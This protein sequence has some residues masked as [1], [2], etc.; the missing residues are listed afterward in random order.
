[1]NLQQFRYVKTIAAA[2]SFSEAAKQLYVTQPSLS[3]AVKE[4]EEEL[5]TELFLRSK[6]GVQ[7]TEAGRDFLVYAQQILAQTEQLKQH[8]AG[9]Q[10]HDF[11]IL[12]QHYDLLSAP[13]LTV[14]NQFRQS[15]Q[16]FH[17]I[18]TTTQQILA[19]LRDFTGDL[20]ILYLDE[21]NRKILERHFTQEGFSYEVLGVFATQIFLRKDHPLA[22]Q[23][24]ILREELAAYPQVRFK[25]EA[26]GGESFEE[27]PLAVTAGGLDLA[28]E[29]ARIGTNERDREISSVKSQQTSGIPHDTNLPE[30]AC[31]VPLQPTLYTN[32]RGTLM[33][34]LVQSDAYASG[35]GI[36]GGFVAEHICLRPLADGTTHQLVAVFNDRRKRSEMAEAFIAA[37]G[38]ALSYE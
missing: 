8:F 33:N 38:E 25:Q 32:D 18:E 27:D 30:A 2:G 13:F 35:L 1:M 24:V 3:Q 20:G 12:S 14:V 17:L 23:K 6:V 7:L 36:I 4:L 15:C 11:T 22:R 26:Y 5:A 31:E 19:G 16:E 37:V 29:M 9:K 10:V 28:D 34:L 21:T